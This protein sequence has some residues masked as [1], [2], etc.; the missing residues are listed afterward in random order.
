MIWACNAL[1]ATHYFLGDFESTRQYAM[2]AVDIWH[3][4]GD[5]LGERTAR[6]KQ[7]H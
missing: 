7:Q 4:G 6:R 3:S 5:L 2:R 1:A